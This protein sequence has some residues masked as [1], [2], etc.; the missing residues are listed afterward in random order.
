MTKLTKYLT[1]MTPTKKMTVSLTRERERERAKTVPTPPGKQ[2]L[3]HDN[4]Q[5]S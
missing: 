1:G 4:F 3:F 2:G 5:G